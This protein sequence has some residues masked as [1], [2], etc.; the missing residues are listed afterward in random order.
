[1]QQDDSSDFG[2]KHDKLLFRAQL[3]YFMGEVEAVFIRD[4]FGIIWPNYLGDIWHRFVAD[5]FGS[6]G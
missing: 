3:F 2:K 1:M 4:T 6:P 5:R